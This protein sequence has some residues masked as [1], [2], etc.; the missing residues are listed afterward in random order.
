MASTKMGL[1]AVLS[2]L[3]MVACAGQANSGKTTLASSDGTSGS[4]KGD[5]T[6]NEVAMSDSQMSDES[7]F[8][9]SFS[10]SE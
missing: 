10:D 8:E 4:A 2:C 3:F 1:V 5:P 9:D 7:M 6:G